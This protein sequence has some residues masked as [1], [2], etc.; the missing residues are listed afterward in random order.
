MCVGSFRVKSPKFW[1]PSQVTPSDFL[2]IWCTSTFTYV[3]N[4]GTFFL[5]VM[6]TL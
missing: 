2:V 1:Q 4:K 5:P 6:D 3:M